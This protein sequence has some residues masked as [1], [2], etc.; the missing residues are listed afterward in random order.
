M[1]TLTIGYSPCPNDTFIMAA[2]AEGRVDTPRKFRPVLADVETLN[3]WAV[4]SRLEVTKL[5]FMALGMV[6]ESYGLLRTG[7]ALGWGCGPLIVSRPGRNLSEL[8][9]GLVAMPGILTSARLLLSLYLGREP[10]SRQ[11]VFS[12]IMPAVARGEVDFG[13]IIHEGRFTYRQHGLIAL[14]DLGEW[15]QAATGR[16]LPLGGIAVR[17]D[18]GEQTARQVDEAISSS[19]KRARENPD[20]PMK[21]VLAHSQEMDPEVTARH[22]DLYVNSF[23]DDLGAAGEQAVATL[24]SRAEEAGLMPGSTLPLMAY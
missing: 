8:E 18:V 2:L 23:S 1:K 5:S 7:S 10:G 17:R 20:E 24:L 14:L 15:W 16:P 21:Y 12:D 19:L 4:E 6:R 22:I 11:M 13:L 9:R 3:Q